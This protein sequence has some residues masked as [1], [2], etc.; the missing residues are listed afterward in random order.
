MQRDLWGAIPLIIAKCEGPRMQAETLD[1]EPD[2]ERR[3]DAS[4][5]SMFRC[6]EKDGGRYRIRT[7]DFHRVKMALYR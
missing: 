4:N 5:S 7:Y 6:K 2:L 3:D 1:R